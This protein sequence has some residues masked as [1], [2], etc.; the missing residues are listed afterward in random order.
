[1]IIQECIPGSYRGKSEIKAKSQY[2]ICEVGNN[3]AEYR[4]FRSLEEDSEI[5]VCVQEVYCS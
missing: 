2:F 5:K 4:R 3:V 1:M